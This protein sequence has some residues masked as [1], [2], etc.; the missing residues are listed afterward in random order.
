M[1]WAGLDWTDLVLYGVVAAGWG[2]VLTHCFE[3]WLLA[4]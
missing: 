3:G 2:E 4:R 1:D